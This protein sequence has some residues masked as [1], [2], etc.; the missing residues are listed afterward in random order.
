MKCPIGGITSSASP[1]FSVSFAHAENTPPGLRLTAMRSV[2][3]CTP[4]QI[5]YDRRTSSPAD[6]G[7]Q[8]QVLAG[9][10]AERLG[11]RRR[12][13]ER[14]RDGVARLALDLRDR[15]AVELAHGIGRRSVR[16]EIVERLEAVE[17]AVMRL[18]RRRAE[19]RHATACCV[20]PQRGHGTAAPRG[21]AG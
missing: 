20:E 1:A 16:L 4:E 2:P 7:A 5:E 17:A 15:Q 21:A 9:G 10:E 3:S 8:R 19:L 6:V 11:Q 18:A 13:G 14:D 12:D